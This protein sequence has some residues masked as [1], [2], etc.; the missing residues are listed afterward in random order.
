MLAQKTLP[1]ELSP[2]LWG[3]LFL[4]AQLL[5]AAKAGFSLGETLQGTPAPSAV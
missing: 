3:L 2:E 4:V 5:M 1:S